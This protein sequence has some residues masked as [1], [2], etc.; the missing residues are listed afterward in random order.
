[1]LFRSFL[2]P[3]V[4]AALYVMLEVV[5]SGRTEYWP[6]AMGTIILVI[7]LAVPEGITGFWGRKGRHVG[8]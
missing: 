6:L 5:I 4:G 2:G 8:H 1:M 7:V 3:V